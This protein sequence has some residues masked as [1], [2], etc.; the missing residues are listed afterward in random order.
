M[1]TAQIEPDGTIRASD[2]STVLSP[3]PPPAARPLSTAL[4]P[5]AAGSAPAELVLRVLAGI[6]LD[7]DSATSVS[8]DGSWRNGPLRGR[9]LVPAARHIGAAARAQARLD[10]LA[11]IRVSLA[12]LDTAHADRVRARVSL[13]E[14]DRRLI[15]H[16][17]TAPR[18]ASLYGARL[19]ADASRGRATN[20]RAAAV[21][22]MTL[23]QQ[24]R[25]RWADE[26]DT[27][28][29][30]CTHHGLPSDIQPLEVI[31]TAAA[32][33]ARHTATLV[34]ELRRLVT[35][36][37]RH[38]EALAEVDEAVTRRT[39]AEDRAD[40]QWRGWSG[41]AS[42]VSALHEA[43]ALDVEQARDELSRSEHAHHQAQATLV[44]ARDAMTTLAPQV[45][46]AEAESQQATADVGAR[47]EDMITAARRFNHRVTLPGLAA[48]ASTAALVAIDRPDDE[49]SVRAAVEA[50]TA[51][52]TKP[53][54]PASANSV[55]TAFQTFDRDVSGQLDAAHQ[56]DDGI[57]LISVVG[58]GDDHS[59][60]GVD[61]AL[62]ARVVQGRAALTE[63][64]R[65]VFTTFVLGG[66]A[67][68]LRRRINQAK[69]L[70]LAMNDS[71]RSIRTSNGIGVRLSWRLVD[72]ATA[73]K[74]IAALVATADAVRT[75]EQSDDLVNLLRGRVE[76]F[77]SGDPSSGYA[78]HLATALDYRRWHEVDVTILGPD[79]GQ[80]RRIS[81]RAKLS[82]GETRFVSY[83]TLF[84]AADAYLTG[85]SSAGSQLRL[86][87]LDDAFAKV[88]DPTIGELMGLLV[89]LDLD[90]VMTG[91][92]LWG[93]FP[94]VPALD[95]Y[96]VRR[97]EG[98]SA[99]TTH[100]HWDGRSRHLRS[101][102]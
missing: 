66:V 20:S 15:A 21:T 16:L 87:L 82:Q 27:H 25:T 46:R 71:L 9:H 100:V 32:D 70:I 88:D 6:G 79:A 2:G 5:D 78:A 35:R 14:L 75:T 62:E 18:S 67:E 101:A 77:Y 13:D 8:V 93:C 38:A 43:I 40:T 17:A 63:R 4:R 29:A 74:R 72:D 53:A 7:D 22:A 37:E 50:T 49:S 65:E 102:G 76:E 33:A 23:A 52:I 97:Q 26:G 69:A 92:A 59:L 60:A 94:E 11:E 96:E 68:E 47:L 12:E 34:D 19:V 28:R 55:F 73:L 58:A 48:A 86:I 3:L 56:L 99:V 39:D 80:E 1:L 51:L 44:R 57:A 30:T 84:A 98:T 36:S 95:I 91:H 41:L 83:V 85:L 45:G 24:A 81:K 64:E 31:T 42:E 89:H 90:F 61:A 10:R 54:Q